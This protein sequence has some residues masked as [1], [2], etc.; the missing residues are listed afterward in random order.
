MDLKTVAILFIAALYCGCGNGDYKTM[1]SIL[2]INVTLQ[3]GDVIFRKGTGMAS[4]VVTTADNDGVYVHVG[5]VVRKGNALMVVHAVPDEHD[6]DG[7]VDRVKLDSLDRFY[8]ESYAS[9]G[10]IMRHGDSIAASMA[11]RKALEVDER[12][13]VFDNDYDDEDTLR[14]CCTELIKF[15]Y[16]STG[17][18]L[19]DVNKHTMKVLNITTNCSFPSDLQRSKYLRTITL[20]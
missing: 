11:A 5:I 6:F 15:V 8:S 19:G 9:R 12:G 10:E 4:R 13:T 7:D 18:P 1:K 17:H 3:E 14:L 16:A 2:P 20:F